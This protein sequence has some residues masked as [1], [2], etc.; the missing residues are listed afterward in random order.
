MPFDPTVFLQQTVTAPMATRIT[1]APEGEWIAVISTAVPIDQ[2]FGEAEW[3][4]K[5]TG[6]QRSQPTCKI[7]FEITDESAK[8]LIKREKIIVSYDMFIDLDA[9]GRL[10]TGEDKNVRLG[11]LRAALN[12][13]NDPTWTFQQ[14]FGAGPLIVK[15]RHKLDEKRGEVFANVT[16]VAKI[17]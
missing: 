3:K 5:N 12:Q 10:D 17:S 14:L 2:W 7:P 9:N 4:D 1:L 13:N 6:A 11:A 15:I 8:L 16:R